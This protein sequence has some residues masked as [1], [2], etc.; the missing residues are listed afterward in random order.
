MALDP[1]PGDIEPRLST[2][3]GS[4]IAIPDLPLDAPERMKKGR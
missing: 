1:A 4:A 3:L 2:K